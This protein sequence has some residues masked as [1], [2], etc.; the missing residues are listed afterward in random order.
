MTEERGIEDRQEN[1][2]FIRPISYLVVVECAYSYLVDDKRQQFTIVEKNS[3]LFQ[4]T[5]QYCIT[6]ADLLYCVLVQVLAS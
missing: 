2:S 5:T 4:P 3:D 1:W 6:N